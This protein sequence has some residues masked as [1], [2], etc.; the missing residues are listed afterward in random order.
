MF[1]LIPLPYKLIGVG[2]LVIGLFG[3][4]YWRGYTNEHIK[5]VAYESQVKAQGEMQANLNKQKEIENDRQTQ[6]VA[7]DYAATTN[8][9]HNQL[10]R[11][12]NLYA[13]GSTVSTV[14]SNSQGLNETGIKLPRSCEDTGYDPCEVSRQFFEGALNDANKVEGFQDWV[15]REHIPV[16]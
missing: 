16:Q 11:L 8:E 10:E 9:L 4:G 15:I 13:G 2:I 12:R 14:A 1:S 5:F 6:Q 3:C 7:Q